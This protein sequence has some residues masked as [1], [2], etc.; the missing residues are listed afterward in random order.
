MWSSS[1]SAS[2]S[3]AVV[4]LALVL[5]ASA[6][7][8]VQAVQPSSDAGRYEIDR[9]GEEQPGSPLRGSPLPASVLSRSPEWGAF[10]SRHPGWT[11]RWDMTLRTPERMQGPP[12]SIPGFAAVDTANAEAAARTFLQDAARPWV[13]AADLVWV[14]TTSDRGGFWVLFQQSHEGVPVWNSRV[15][16]RLTRGGRVILLANR[17]YPRMPSPGAFRVSL[18]AALEAAR[19]ELPGAPAPLGEPVLTFLPIRR[20]DHYEQ[21]LTWRYEFRTQDPPGAWTSFVDA[22]DGSL[23][24]RFNAVK[25]ADVYGQVTG[26]VE[27]LTPGVNLRQRAFP[28]VMVACLISGSG[29][30]TALSGTDGTYSLHTASAVGRTL[31]VPLAGPYGTVSDANSGRVPSVSRGVPDGD[32]ARVDVDFG[33]PA[34]TIAERDAYSS[35]LIA[36]ARIKTIEPTLTLMDYSM[37]IVVNINLTCNAF[38]NGYG[39]NFYQEGDGCVNTAR[40][41]DVV[42]HEYGHG[43]TDLMY[44]PFYPSGAMAEGFSDY[45]AASITGQ[46]VIGIGFRGP[47]TFLRRID[48]D[49]VYPQD[50]VGED[51]RDG[52]IIAS[53]LW[54]LRGVLGASRADSLFHFARY[55]HA[56]N[57]DDYFFDVLVADDDNGDVYDGTPNL[58][59]IAGVFRPHGIGD[60]GIHVSHIPHPDTEDTT[61]PLSLTASF[62]GVYAL[63]PGSVRVHT[64]TLRRGETT[65][66]DLP[67]T[68]TG[69]PREYTVT[70]PAQPA[71]TRIGYY[72]AASDTAGGTV[73]WPES[74]AADP[75]IFQVGTDTTPPQ[76]VHEGLPDQPVDIAALRVRA[77]V[78]DNL[79][80]PV[81][82]VSL[83]SRRNAGATSTSAMS[84][85]AGTSDFLGEL[86]ATDLV[87]GDSVNYRILAEDGATVVN[88]GVQPAEGWNSFRIV[89][90]FERDLEANN[91]GLLGSGDWQ[92][93]HSSL[94]PAYSGQNVWGTVLDG[95]YHDGTRSV[96]ECAPIDLS[97]FVLA[98]L[99]FR[100]F[101]A[102]EQDYDGGFVE[103][104]VDGGTTWDLV[105]PDGDY[106]ARIL[107]AD[108]TPGYS[109]ST[110]GW[111]PARFDLFRYVG[112]PDLRIRFTFASDEGVAGLGWYLDDVSVVERQVLSR[113]MNL[114]ARSGGDRRVPLRWDPPAG[115][116]ESE[117]SPVTGYNVYRSVGQKDQPQL[118]TPEPLGVR[119][120]S[121]TT[122][123]NGVPYEYYATA[124]YAGGREGP[125][126][127]P[128]SAM[129]YRAT[130]SAG[131]ASISAAIDSS[132]VVDTTVVV[133]NAGTGF[134]EMN[135]Y[136][137][138]SAQTIDD[139]RLA[140]LLQPAG[141]LFRAQVWDTVG[142]D[143]DDPAGTDP[144]LAALLVSQNENMLY[145]RVTMQEAT[146]ALTDSTSLVI[147]LDT[148]GNVETGFRGG[149]VVVVAGMIALENFDAQVALLD[150]NFQPVDGLA[151]GYILPDRVEFALTKDALGRPD[152]ISVSVTAVAAPNDRPVDTMPAG[153]STRWLTVNPL[154]YSV[155]VG[156]A[157]NLGLALSSEALPAGSYKAKVFLETN[158]PALRVVE[159]PVTFRVR[160]GTPVLLSGLSA[161]AREEGVVLF[162]R[163]QAD[164][165][166][167]GFDIYR[168][169]VSPEEGEEVR[170]TSEPLPRAWNGEYRFVDT[171]A[172]PG[173]Q[174]EYR[175]AA[176][177]P[178]GS[179]EFFGPLTVTTKGADLPQVLSLGPCVPNPARQTTTVRYG[180]PRTE[181]NVRLALYGPG[182]RLV[183]TLVPG[184][185]R[186]AG[187][188]VA[189]WDGRDDRGQ[190]VAAGL[191]F[192]LLE[193]GRQHRT[194]KVLLVR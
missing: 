122:A 133:R 33:E 13:P 184:G 63:E 191:Y 80:R 158:D 95:I 11:A 143:P 139:V 91:G 61:L 137:A 155:T 15:S 171:G 121:D 48:T 71:G 148:D 43:I 40:V 126:S 74:G 118:L 192:V 57:F 117:P 84:P 25:Y 85:A 113:P 174:Y 164:L 26:T 168:R 31:S 98:G 107:G 173:R 2:R 163:A 78:T 27:P 108:G 72:F 162:W 104:S 111:V 59:A 10:V 28:D 70:L 187:Y 62:L 89:R 32:S 112:Q 14:R 150:G 21:R 29:Q 76:I 53:A 114:R 94:V 60:Y 194:Q 22:A 185:G 109:G 34:A 30:V 110:G 134:L 180:L 131:L 67:M 159:M 4:M 18:P 24:W 36:H 147:P 141:G 3:L 138:D 172:L 90:G 75:F 106:G 83:V 193:T 50:W 17:T 145:L 87:L 140:I 169:V 9:R 97:E 99:Y 124:V 77:T 189:T 49:Y 39:I 7:P 144:D 127:T 152:R 119:L 44:R 73:T 167:A 125:L 170:I 51:H 116:V 88:V 135:A 101:L 102:C 1:S 68:P 19:A 64:E 130:F 178:D 58:D 52:L 47:G 157:Q 96:L 151:Y 35:A 188:Y 23:L 186:D 154:H 86:S 37:P 190:P 136:V 160:T 176:L 146:S 54:D 132:G 166:Y 20:S 8:G 128:A 142:T 81:R 103:V 129:A 165:G 181:E 82:S 183:R 161:E 92:W 177:A 153:P 5:S 38:W 55:G 105:R 175:V 41:A 179:R 182:G 149:D 79:D 56:D 6:A 93:G 42:Y 123:V 46:P 115:V 66:A 45:F 100:Y 16:V 65:S 69:N 12:L 156:Q 120:Y